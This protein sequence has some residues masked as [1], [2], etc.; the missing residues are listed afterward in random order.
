MTEKI[1]T[2]NYSRTT[3]QDLR[4][5]N[6]KPRTFFFKTNPILTIK[7]AAQLSQLKGLTVILTKSNVKETNPNEPNVKIGNMCLACFYIDKSADKKR[8]WG[9]SAENGFELGVKLL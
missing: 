8:R 4:T 3:N 5:T 2:I 7:N 1:S 9:F 6:Y